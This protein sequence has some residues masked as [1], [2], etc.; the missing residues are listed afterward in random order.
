MRE[1]IGRVTVVVCISCRAEAHRAFLLERMT[2]TLGGLCL[3]SGIVEDID[4]ADDVVVDKIDQS[5]DF[6]MQDKRLM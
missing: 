6:V 5:V 2:R 1:H 3:R 4:A